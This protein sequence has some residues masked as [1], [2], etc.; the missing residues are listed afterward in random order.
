DSLLRPVISLRKSLREQAPQQS[1]KKH[2]GVR[3]RQIVPCRMYSRR[4]EQ[5]LPPPDP[6]FDEK[7]RTVRKGSENAR[8]LSGSNRIRRIIRIDFCLVAGPQQPAALV[9]PI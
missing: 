6:P 8:L 9:V 4:D 1:V 5:H 3:P 2:H 7:R